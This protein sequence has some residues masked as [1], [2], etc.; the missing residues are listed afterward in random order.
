[1]VSGDT[2]ISGAIDVIASP[3]TRSGRPISDAAMADTKVSA[4][5]IV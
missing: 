3:L 1:M 5:T 2:L 4:N